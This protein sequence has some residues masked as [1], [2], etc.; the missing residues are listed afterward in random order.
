MVVNIWNI[1]WATFR[2]IC[3]SIFEIYGGQPLN[4]MLVIIWNIL[5]LTFEIYVGHY[6]KHMV[7]N[8]WRTF[9]NSLEFPSSSSR[10]TLS[11]FTCYKNYNHPMHCFHRLKIYA[12]VHFWASRS[13]ATCLY[14]MARVHRPGKVATNCLL[15]I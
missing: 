3:W 2:I 12:Y 15:N 7:V 8:I 4:Y 5:W 14:W 13:I 1:C 11:T 10:M 9:Y 6:L